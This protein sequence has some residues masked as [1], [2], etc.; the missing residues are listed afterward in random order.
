[1]RCSDPTW[2][3][4]IHLE[5]SREFPEISSGYPEIS[6]HILIESQISWPL[7]SRER[8]WS[9]LRH[10][11]DLLWYPYLRLIWHCPV[12]LGDLSWY[13]LRFPEVLIPGLVNSHKKRTGKW[14][15]E[16]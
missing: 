11:E 9:I 2:D 5:M 8:S 4:L 3:I 6:C 10:P 12:I 1:L 7:L 15:I 16:I 14:T 13:L